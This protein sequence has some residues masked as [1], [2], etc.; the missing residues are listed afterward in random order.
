MGHPR[1]LCFD[2][3]GTCVD[4]RGSIVAEG[5]TWNRERGLTTN[6]GALADAWRARYQPSMEAVRVGTRPF[7]KLDVLHRESLEEIAPRFGLGGLDAAS[8]D[9][10]TRIWH[11]LDPWPDVRPG[12]EQMA[13]NLTLA[14]L[15]NGGEELL[16]ALA[17]RGNLPWDHCLGA[18][19]FQAYKPL[20]EVYIRAARLLGLAPGQVMM[21][22]AH[23]SDLRAAADE[24]LMTAFVSRRSE[25]GPAQATDLGP[26]GPWDICAEDFVDLAR[27]LI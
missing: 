22:A 3:F 8:L 9:E 14:T 13:G 2:V 19:T 15:S 25:Y 16:R 18:E 4:W 11:R 17:T 24:G 6:W 21:V 1:A 20:P 5:E 12:L 23:N 10:L 27:H 26:D 7:V